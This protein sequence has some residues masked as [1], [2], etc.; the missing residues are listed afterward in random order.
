[1]KPIPR[2]ASTSLQPA[3][4]V[5]PV[6]KPVDAADGLAEQS[7]WLP[8]GSWLE[9]ATGKRFTGPMSVERPYAIDQVPVFVRPGA[10]VPEQPAMLHTG[11]KPVDPLVLEVYP[12]EDKQRSSYELYEDSGV[13]EDYARNVGTA[14]TGITAQQ[15]GDTLTVAKAPVKGSYAGMVGRRALELRLPADWP[16]ASVSVNGTPLKQ[17]PTRP[18][19]SAGASMATA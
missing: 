11:Q 3:F 1:M 4:L 8:K 5:A 10:I 18:A 15:A 14:R 12:L 2:R 6:V 7:I 17:L 9:Q 16:P 19:R 13:S